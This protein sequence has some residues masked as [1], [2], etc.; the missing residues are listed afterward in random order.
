M[1]R[2]WPGGRR[3]AFTFCDDTDWATRDNVQ[4][5]YEFLDRLGW[6]TTKL[7]WMSRRGEADVN[8]GDTCDDAPYLDWL[9]SLQARGFEI[10]LHNVA[11]STSTREEIQRGLDRF[12]QLFGAPPRLHCNHT[13]CRDNLYWGDERLTGWR[14]RLYNR[15]THGARRQASEGHLADS[16]YFWGDLLRDRISYVR[17]FTFDSLNTLAQ[18]PEMPY[19]DPA[20]PFV[21]FWFAA[22][23]AS[24]PRYF[25]QNFTPAAI[26]RLIEAGGLC[27]AYTHFGAQFATDGQ[28]DE[29]FKTTIESIAAR[30]PW[31][32]P[33]YNVLDYLRQGGDPAARQLSAF[34][35]QRLEL[36]WMRGRYGKKMGI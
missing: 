20:R 14:R 3:F 12:A 7:V 2:S 30:D 33:V 29:Y 34:A 9:Q 22:T 10:G 23:T 24:S 25:R 26:E 31:V 19:H 36:R 28:L 1:K 17:N 27:I 35:R 8:A 13:G 18:C 15:Y 11:P 4:P 5:V 21:K 6:R 32:A 16:P